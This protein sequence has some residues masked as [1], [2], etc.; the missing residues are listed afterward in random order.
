MS[1]EK[2]TALVCDKEQ[3]GAGRLGTMRLTEGASS[4]EGASSVR[5]AGR[6]ILAAMSWPNGPI[7]RYLKEI[8]LGVPNDVVARD[9]LEQVK[10]KGMRKFWIE[11]AVVYTAR[12]RVYVPHHG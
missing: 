12:R 9:L 3:P 7:V 5:T 8:R 1:K 4:A 2:L 10:D 11:D 6:S